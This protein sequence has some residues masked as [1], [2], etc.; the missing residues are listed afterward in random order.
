MKIVIAEPIAERL[1]VLISEH[2]K[3]WTVYDTAPASKQEFI[4]RLQGAE[5]ACAYSYIFDEEVMRACPTIKHLVIPAVG[6]SSYV[7]MDYAR[8]NGITVQN[9]PGYNAET[10]AE[11]A[12]GLAIDVG[13]Q[14]TRRHSLLS[15]GEWQHTPIGSTLLSGKKIGLVGYGNVGKTIE[16]LLRA[17]ST[18]VDHVNSGSSDGDLTRLMGESDVVIVCCPLTDKTEG[19]IRKE[20]LQMMKPSSIFINVARGAIVDEDALYEV[21]TKNR[22]KGAGLDVFC[23]EPEQNSAVSESV[24]RFTRLLN[25]VCT[26]HVAGSSAE[27]SVNLGDMLFE[28]IESCELGRLSNLFR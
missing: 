8:A 14:I 15:E 2:K 20:L 16:K 4:E 13:R 3:D 18:E 28:N 5:V 27:S 21:L 17:W 10:V 12:I 6:A 25:V 22:I 7:D 11:M 1:D 23:E 24:M 19:M 9:C 26:S